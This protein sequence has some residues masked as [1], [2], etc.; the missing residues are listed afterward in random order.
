M[1]NGYSVG[2]N[3]RKEIMDKSNGQC[4]LLGGRCTGEA[5]TLDHWV[6]RSKGGSNKTGNLRP[7]CKNCNEDKGDMT[8][9]EWWTK[10][11]LIS[12]RKDRN[13]GKGDA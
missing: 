4:V 12:W 8:P 6:P 13:N 2:A 7:S 10:R 11:S 1:G 3:R 9:E 5:T